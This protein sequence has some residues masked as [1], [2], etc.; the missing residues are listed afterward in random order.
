MTVK[1]FELARQEFESKIDKLYSLEGFDADGLTDVYPEILDINST[2]GNHQLE[3]WL[4]I[5]DK[6]S[7]KP[8]LTMISRFTTKA[9]EYD[10][11]NPRQGIDQMWIRVY[12]KLTPDVFVFVRGDEDTP[13]RVEINASTISLGNKDGLASVNNVVLDVPKSLTSIWERKRD[14]WKVPYSITFADNWKSLVQE[15]RQQDSTANLFGA[16]VTDVLIHNYDL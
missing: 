6:L 5:V 7:M 8:E 12:R 16:G 1:S 11:R 14:E 3:R 13:A 4:E 9:L 2:Y 15:A 10:T